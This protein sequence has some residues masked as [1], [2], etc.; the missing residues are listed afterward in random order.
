MSARIADDFEAIRLRLAEMQRERD[1]GRQKAAES[2]MAEVAPAAP[3]PEPLR[4]FETIRVGPDGDG[5]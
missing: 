1:E 4:R 3:Q 2:G 5:A